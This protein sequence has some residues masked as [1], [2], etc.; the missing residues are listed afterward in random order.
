MA[1]EPVRDT[2]ADRAF[3][4]PI[5]LIGEPQYFLAP[6]L[7][8]DPLPYIVDYAGRPITATGK[9]LFNDQYVPGDLGDLQRQV[10]AEMKRPI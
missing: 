6:I 4:E 1:N 7:A 8:R 2:D 5:V 3:S 10:V 9:R